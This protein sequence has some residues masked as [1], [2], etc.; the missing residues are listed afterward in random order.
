[1]RNEDLR[2]SFVL[3]R[4]LPRGTVNLAYKGGTPKKRG[5][6]R[7]APKGPKRAKTGIYDRD[8]QTG[9]KGIKQGGSKRPPQPGFGGRG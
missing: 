6:F 9:Q 7:G 4:P 2:N 1:M 5:F 3:T 8:A